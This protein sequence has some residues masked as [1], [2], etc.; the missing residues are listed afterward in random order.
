MSPRAALH[1]CHRTRG[2][3]HLG[4]QPAGLFAVAGQLVDASVRS[5]G[6]ARASGG[7]PPPS[8]PARPARLVPSVP[9]TAAPVQ[10]AGQNPQVYVCGGRARD[11]EHRVGASPSSCPVGAE[12]E[13]GRFALLTT[14]GRSVG[15][16]AATAASSLGRSPSGRSTPPTSPWTGPRS[17]S[18][19]RR[20]ARYGDATGTPEGRAPE[21]PDR[22][23]PSTRPPANG[24]PPRLP[25]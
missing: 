25:E 4:Q 13:Y 19:P 1:A 8:S 10:F 14:L 5:S 3:L 21:M 15:R 23:R 20:C 9:P 12:R 24:T 2:L 22:A 16:H 18:V 7:S 11:G 17:A 6:P